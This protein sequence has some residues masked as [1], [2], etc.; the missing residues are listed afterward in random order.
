MKQNKNLF[1]KILI[2]SWTFLTTK[3]QPS[4]QFFIPIQGIRTLDKTNQTPPKKPNLTTPI[5]Q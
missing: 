3:H 4:I 2:F 5:H 1:N